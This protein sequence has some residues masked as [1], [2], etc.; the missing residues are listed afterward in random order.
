M[1]MRTAKQQEQY[2][3]SICLLTGGYSHDEA[4]LY[5]SAPD[6]L[7]ALQAIIAESDGGWRTESPIAAQALAAIAK[8]TKEAA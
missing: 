6:L 8:A 7:A 5:A 4:S 3:V 1:T 2:L